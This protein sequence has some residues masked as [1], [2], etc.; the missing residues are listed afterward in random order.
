MSHRGFRP[1][2]VGYSSYDHSG[3]AP[4]F[5]TYKYSSGESSA[6]EPACSINNHGAKFA[7][8]GPFSVVAL[9]TFEIVGSPG[10]LASSPAIVR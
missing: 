6:G 9:K 4:V 10:S 3:I 5:V 7:S 2:H 1:E 8:G